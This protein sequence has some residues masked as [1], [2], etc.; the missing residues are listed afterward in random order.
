MGE[1]VDVGGGVVGLAVPGVTEIVAAGVDVAVTSG[2]VQVS[3][4]SA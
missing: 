1:G 2:V 3:A 4:T